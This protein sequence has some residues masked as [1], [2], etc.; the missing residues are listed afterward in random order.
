[1][2][3]RQRPA[4]GAPGQ[5]FLRSSRLAEELVEDAG[6]APGDL[7]LDVGAGD[8]A[9]TSALVRAGARVCALELD[10]A[11]AA[12]LRRRFSDANVEVQAVD[13]RL[14]AWPR[15]PFHVVANLPFAG[16]GAILEHLLRDPETELRQALVIVQWE[17]AL[18][19]ARVWPTTVRGAC[20]QA[21]FE[22]AV[23][24]RLA[25][26]AFA[27]APSVDAA[28]LRI[29]R[30]AVPLVPPAEHVRYRRLLETA[31]RAQHPLVRA[32]RPW[33][34]PRELRRLSARLGFDARSR[35]RELDPAQWAGV[36][37]FVA[38]RDGRRP[39][40]RTRS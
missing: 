25:R 2:A 20:W 40:R 26:S 30:R 1:M 24:R 13:A 10:P 32:L 34:S 18:K 16:S 5:H 8:G 9:L 17:L 21:W 4:R 36:Y 39:P 15:E 28:V 37:A 22:L 12:S 31:F 7:V 38:S 6:I 19:H 11:L 29:G 33:L 27:P 23:T 14:A 3:V 35:P